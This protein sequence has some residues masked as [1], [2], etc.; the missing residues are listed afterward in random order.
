MSLVIKEGVIEIVFNKIIIEFPLIKML[1]LCL[2]MKKKLW[3]RVVSKACQS[4]VKSGGD[5]KEIDPSISSSS[6]L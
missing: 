3:L 6:S 2:S 1:S 5:P 4:K